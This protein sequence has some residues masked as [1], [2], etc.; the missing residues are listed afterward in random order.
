[1][2]EKGISHE[3]YKQHAASGM[4]EKYSWRFGNRLTGTANE[5]WCVMPENKVEN[6]V[7]LVADSMQEN[8]CKMSTQVISVSGIINK[9]LS[10]FNGIDNFSYFVIW[11][12]F[13]S[14]FNLYLLILLL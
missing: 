8:P 5:S 12:Y 2:K 14:L 7:E 11:F 13:I 10:G 6:R 1:L 9:Y 4:P 3:N